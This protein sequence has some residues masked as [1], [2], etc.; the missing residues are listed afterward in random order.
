MKRT[1]LPLLLLPLLFSCQTSKKEP[2]GEK[3]IAG[4]YLSTDGKVYVDLL[5]KV[6][7]DK[8][9][10]NE[11]STKKE[12]TTEI[13]WGRPG[14]I[15]LK[16]S[17]GANKLDSLGRPMVTQTWFIIGKDSVYTDIGNKNIDS[18][19]KQPFPKNN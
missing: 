15:P 5:L 19:L 16:D 8:I 11:D 6:V 3:K 13:V 4:I 12:V 7:V 17:L 10:Y 1:L 18:L 9:K 14:T 2:A